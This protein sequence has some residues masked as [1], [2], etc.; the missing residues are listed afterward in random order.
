M[1][2]TPAFTVTAAARTAILEARAD[3]FDAESLALWLEVSA[4]SPLKFSYD[5]YFQAAG[6]ARPED[7]VIRHD[8]I[9]VVIPVA[10]VERLRGATLDVAEDGSG[11]VIVNPNEPKI[12]DFSSLGDAAMSGPVAER[13]AWVLEHQI[14]PQ[15]A[16]HG[17]FAE[18]VAVEDDTVYL[19]MGGGCQGCGMAKVTLS[20]GI[21]VAIREAVPEIVNI[22][23]VTDHASGSDP[24]YQAAKK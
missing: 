23:D 10:S 20:Q 8:D 2:D 11:M 12:P 1:Q 5:M 17:G 7:A 13:V 9:D 4:A 21:E 22:V 14:N 3:E 18:L 15:I 16:S 19:R 6:D 24:Y